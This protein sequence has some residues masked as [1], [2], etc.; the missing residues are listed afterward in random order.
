MQRVERLLG[1]IKSPQEERKTSTLPVATSSVA[2]VATAAKVNS[3]KFTLN[4]NGYLT[5]EQRD[6]YEKNG[7]IVIKALY[8]DKELEVYRKRFVDIANGTIERAPTMTMMRDIVL[9][10]KK[11]VKGEHLIT[12]LQDWQDDEVLFQYCCAPPIVR[13]VESIIGPAFKSVHTMLINKPPDL[14]IGSSRHP[15]HQD[16]WYFPFRPANMIVCSWTAMQKITKENGCLCVDPGTHTGK[17]FKH[18]YPNDGVVNKAYHGI[19]GMT[20]ADTFSLVHLEMEP[21]DTVFFH[22]LLVHGSGRNHSK[23]YRKA[24]SCHYAATTCHYEDMDG[25]IQEELAREVE[26]M[27]KIHGYELAFN[28]IWKLKSRLIKGEE[29]TL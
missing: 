17:L 28:D 12:K 11:D 26:G 29:G 7:F 22:P 21:G 16:L 8:P 24:I 18:S 14:G 19:Q 23:G 15:L 2:P 13:V 4:T 27:A 3:H 25:T 10:K 6:F 5:L 1:H 9:A 20:E